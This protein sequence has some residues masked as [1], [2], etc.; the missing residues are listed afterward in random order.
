MVTSCEFS[1]IDNMQKNNYSEVN[2]ATIESENY[3][4]KYQISDMQFELTL[5]RKVLNMQLEIDSLKE[6]VN[7]LKNENTRLKNMTSYQEIEKQNEIVSSSKVFYSEE[8]ARLASILTGNDPHLAQQ[9]HRPKRDVFQVS[10][11]GRDN[12]ERGRHEPSMHRSVSA[13]ATVVR[14]N[15]LRVFPA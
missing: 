15:G 5:T 11:W 13:G 3:L 12:V 1:S 8:F 7:E 14:I 2:T 9:T 4:L 6:Q 10:N